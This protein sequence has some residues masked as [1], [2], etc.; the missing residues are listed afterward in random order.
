[1]KATISTIECTLDSKQKL[2]E[3]G[4]H[5]ATGVHLKFDS[6]AFKGQGTVPT[7]CFITIFM[8]PFLFMEKK[9]GSRIAQSVQQWFT[10]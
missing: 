6:I 8:A 4:T 2:K 10:G 5:R 7:S 1:M 9:N 3:S